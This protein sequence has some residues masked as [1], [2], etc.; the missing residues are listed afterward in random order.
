MP[1]DQNLLLQSLTLAMRDAAAVDDQLALTIVQTAVNNLKKS[2]DG[3]IVPT[4]QIR[5]AIAMELLNRELFE[6]HNAYFRHR[7]H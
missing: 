3:K 1:F 4:A 6:I 5:R 2:G 7:F